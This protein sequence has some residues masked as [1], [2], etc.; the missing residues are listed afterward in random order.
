[1]KKP[2]SVTLSGVVLQKI[3]EDTIKY[4]HSKSCI[5]NDILMKHYGITASL[6][7]PRVLTEDEVEAAYLERRCIENEDKPGGDASFDPATF[8]KHAV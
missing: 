3:A 4:D 7:K 8:N 6:P 5:I 1:M 2:I